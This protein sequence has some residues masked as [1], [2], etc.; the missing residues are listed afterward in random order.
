[1]PR[2][3]EIGWFTR[4]CCVEGVL[5]PRCRDPWVFLSSGRADDN[6][7]MELRDFKGTKKQSRRDVRE[8]L[9]GVK[10]MFVG[11]LRSFVCDCN[12]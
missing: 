1:M 6:V 2:E 10:V 12:S 4:S 3:R 5:P 11:K 7:L 8:S 9:G